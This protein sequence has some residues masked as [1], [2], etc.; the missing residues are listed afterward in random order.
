[1][2][3]RQPLS[4]L[5]LACALFSGAT[6]AA[7]QLHI[8]NWNDYIAEDTIA[9]FEKKFDVKV[10]YD[11]F[12]SNE[13]LEGK[14]LSGASGYDIV[15]P[16]ANFLGKQVQAG[17]FAELDKSKL[18][19]LKHLDQSLLKPLEK[20]D[21]GNKH[22]VPYLW[23]TIGIGYNAEK[24]KEV[25]GENAPV[26]SLDLI[27]KPENA[28]KLAKCGIN[29][30]DSGS[31]ILPL[32]LNYIGLPSQ[33][34]KPGDYSKAAAK[35]GEVRQHIRSFNGSNYITDLAN[36]NICVA[37]GYSGD[38]LQAAAAAKEA[39]KPYTIAYSIPKEGSTLWFD[40][41]AIPA[42]AKNRENAYLFINYILQ[43]EVIAPISN[44]VSY[45]N[46]NRD[47][48]PLV[49]KAITSNTG[50]YPPQETIDRLWVSDILP[51]KIQRTI[52]RT[53]TKIKT[54]K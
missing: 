5:A 27:L 13:V 26:D 2:I 32:V 20:L 47:A 44:Y 49:D 3:N 46:P 15:V 30:L 35:L 33:S 41:M 45:A 1:M 12:D 31:E 37:V 51:A 6:Q 8:Y 53:W 23:G 54:G 29:L 43:P 21:P 16:T 50:I 19:N 7:G 11:L 25:L 34:T 10:T 14:L 36:G 52:T 24:V 17:V 42:D 28:E 38:I 4:V 9:N 22:G 48:T 40:M 18:P 39:K